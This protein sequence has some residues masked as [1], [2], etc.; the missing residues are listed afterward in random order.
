MQKI[1]E[2]TQAICSELLEYMADLEVKHILFA[3]LFWLMVFEKWIVPN[4]VTYTSI[5]ASYF[6]Q[7]RL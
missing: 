2:R 6:R 3:T 4:A 7:E 5:I 1:N